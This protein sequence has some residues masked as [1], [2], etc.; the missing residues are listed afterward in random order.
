[1][2]TA[3]GRHA[4]ETR[5]RLE[6]VKVREDLATGLIRCGIAPFYPFYAYEDSQPGWLAERRS[7]SP[8]RRQAL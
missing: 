2:G 5:A 8:A 3:L 1:M 6:Q 4:L 7:A